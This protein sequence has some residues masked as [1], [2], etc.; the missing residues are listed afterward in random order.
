MT[1]NPN[2]TLPTTP[3]IQ[4]L[5]AALKQTTD[6][7]APTLTTYLNTIG[8]ITSV[9]RINTGNYSIQFTNPLALPLDKTLTGFGDYYGSA[10]TWKIIAAVG[11]IKG[12]YTM[13]PT[14]E[15]KITIEIYDDSWAAADLHVLAGDSIIEIEIQVIN[16]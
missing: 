13:Y 11:D 12:Y 4:T 16:N 1:Q 7:G 5:K 8:A 10:T 9:T 3:K 6:T 15:F 14:Q 2:T